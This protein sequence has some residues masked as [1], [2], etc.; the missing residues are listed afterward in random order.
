MISDM[1]GAV[2][3]RPQPR[4]NWQGKTAETQVEARQMVGSQCNARIGQ[5][6]RD[7]CKVIR[8]LWLL[9]VDNYE[10]YRWGSFNKTEA[11]LTRQGCRLRTRSRQDR[12][13]LLEAEADSLRQDL[14][15]VSNVWNTDIEGLMIEC[16]N[17]YFKTISKLQCLEARQKIRGHNMEVEARSRWGI[18]TS[19]QGRCIT[20]ATSRRDFCFETSTGCNLC[21]QICTSVLQQGEWRNTFILIMYNVCVCNCPAFKLQKQRKFLQQPAIKSTP[22][23]YEW[24]QSEYGE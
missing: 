10:W 4:Q 9:C 24:L 21:V 19:R 11:E 3:T 6:A 1:G 13:R 16:Y 23:N 20:F 2:F 22:H 12:D 18:K 8:K 15:L 5:N 14:C 17:W 7:Q